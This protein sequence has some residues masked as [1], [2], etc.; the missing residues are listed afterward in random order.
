M[1]EQPLTDLA[2]LLIESDISQALSLDTFVDT[3]TV[4]DQNCKKSIF[5]AKCSYC[6]E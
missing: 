4:K 1:G 2:L 5:I 6:Y 3:F